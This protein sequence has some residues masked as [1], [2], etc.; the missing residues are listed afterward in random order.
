MYFRGAGCEEAR[1]VGSFHPWSSSSY[2]HDRNP[3]GSPMGYLR[4]FQSFC[5]AVSFL[6]LSL[7]KILLWFAM[8][9]VPSNISECLFLGSSIH[10]PVSNFI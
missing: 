1:T 10:Y 6:V 7:S 4:C 2:S 5:W 3:H 8:F 9:L